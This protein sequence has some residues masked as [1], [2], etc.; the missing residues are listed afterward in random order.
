MTLTRDV[1][2]WV[3]SSPSVAK[4]NYRLFPEQEGWFDA[5]AQ[6]TVSRN[7]DRVSLRVPAEGAAP[8][9]VFRGVL[10][11][12]T[13]SYLASAR[14][15]AKIGRASGRERVCP[16]CRSRWAPYP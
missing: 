13:K 14:P 5:A 1:Q 6:Q 15:V 12:G 16:S 7:G 11:S 10:A 8:A 9:N 2:D 3:F 4:G